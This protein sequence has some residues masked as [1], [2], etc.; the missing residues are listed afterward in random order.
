M[1][2]IFIAILVSLP[3]FLYVPNEMFDLFRHYER[4][5]IYLYTGDDKYLAEYVGLSFL[6]RLMSVGELN[7][8]FM[9]FFSS[10]FL[11]LAIFGIGTYSAS[12]NKLSLSKV[13]TCFLPF[14]AFQFFPLISGVRF[15]LA[16]SF[17]VFGVLQHYKKGFFSKLY[18]MLSVFFHAGMII[19]V[20]VFYLSKLIRVKNLMN[21]L[22]VIFVAIISAIIISVYVSNIGVF[23][24]YLGI[25]KLTGINV[26]EYLSGT[27]GLGAQNNLPETG[28]ISFFIAKITTYIGI[29]SFSIC[30][31]AQ[32]ENDRFVFLAS[33]FLT[34]TSTLVV[35]SGRFE[36]LVICF[37]LIPVIMNL[38]RTGRLHL[39]ELILIGAVAVRFSL[40]FWM[41]RHEFFSI[42]IG[43]FV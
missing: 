19:M 33:V 39:Y 22:A 26:G 37:M 20:I 25:D 7:A 2:K 32:T 21:R 35:I 30:N 10:F 16:I 6:M 42:Y 43:P 8:E 38:Q 23:L 13:L 9:A 4:Y 14:L 34:L 41:F 15:A 18:M 28:K 24:A 29:L 3:F 27:Y 17:F 1:L 31:S 5:N 40:D 36:S 11:V 12:T